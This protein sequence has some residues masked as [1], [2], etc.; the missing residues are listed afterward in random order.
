M[1]VMAVHVDVHIPFPL[2]LLL[3]IFLF[4]LL[5]FYFIYLYIFSPFLCSFPVVLV[6]KSSITNLQLN[7]DYFKKQKCLKI[8]FDSKQYCI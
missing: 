7:E 3:F 5:P 6:F 1:D 4:F 2:F 8:S